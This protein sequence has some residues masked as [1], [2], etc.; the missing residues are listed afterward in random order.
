MKKILALA[1]AMILAVSLVSCSLGEMNKL[2]GEYEG[3]YYEVAEDLAVV[4]NFNI[5]N[6]FGIPAYQ[7]MVAFGEGAGEVSQG[8]VYYVS[9][10]GDVGGTD[11]EDG[12]YYTAEFDAETRELLYEDGSYF[13]SE[14]EKTAKVNALLDMMDYVLENYGTV[15]TEQ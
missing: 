13:A 3:Y 8:V 7:E 6:I 4:A 5:Y 14:E 9:I 12:Y 11:A 10:G 15:T 1:L 2:E